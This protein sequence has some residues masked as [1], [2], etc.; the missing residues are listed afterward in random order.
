MPRLSSTELT[1]IMEQTAAR[2]DSPAE[3]VWTTVGTV[4]GTPDKAHISTSYAEQAKLSIGMG[5][6]RFT[7]LTNAFSKKVENHVCGLALSFSYGNDVR[8]HQTLRMSP[9]MAA[10]AS[11]TLWYGRPPSRDER[12]LMPWACRHADRRYRNRSDRMGGLRCPDRTSS[13]TLYSCRLC[14][15]PFQ[16]HQAAT[17][18]DRP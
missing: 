3:C 5:L 4:T 1:S 10:G 18:S 14:R 6:R 7:R 17:P 12:P 16:N 13:R 8:T 9:A 15:Q 11:K 2:R